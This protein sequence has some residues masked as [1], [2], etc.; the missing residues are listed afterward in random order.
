VSIKNSK[1]AD[2]RIIVDH[3]KLDFKGIFDSKG[4]FKMIGDWFNNRGI[5]K[6]EPKNFEQDLP[7]GKYI[8]YEI[9]YWKKVT[10]YNRFIYKIRALFFGLK[11]VDVMHEKKKMRLSQGRVLIYFDAYIEHDYENRWERLPFLIFLRTIFD[12]FVYKA[13][14]ERFERRISFDAHDLYN[15][16][17]K[18]L[19]MYRHYRP[20][21]KIPHFAH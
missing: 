18:F 21:A 5:Q 20:V 16:V 1:M 4:L 9:A 10:D 7:D 12:K 19:N 17:E 2:V 13:Y 3:L 11:K 6:R 15:E 8:E 14:T